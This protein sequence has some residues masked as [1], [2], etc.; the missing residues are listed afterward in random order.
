MIL[1]AP[2]AAAGQTSASTTQPQAA[3]PQTQRVETY[4]LSIT[5]RTN[6]ILH[7]RIRVPGSQPS[8]EEFRIRADPD[9]LWGASGVM[10]LLMASY[11]TKRA[12]VIYYKRSADPQ[13][14]GEITGVDALSDEPPW[15]ANQPGPR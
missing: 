5:A 1:A 11:Q 7:F 2:A 6:G 13:Y 3:P 10:G 4:V 15:H 9:N 8:G 14:V 12:V